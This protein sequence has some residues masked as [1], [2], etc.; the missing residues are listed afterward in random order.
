MLRRTPADFSGALAPIHWQAK[1]P[2]LVSWINVAIRT[3]SDNANFAGKSAR[4][5]ETWQAPDCLSRCART[6]T[7]AH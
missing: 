4:T 7:C 6:Q 5:E 3:V 2:F 1:R